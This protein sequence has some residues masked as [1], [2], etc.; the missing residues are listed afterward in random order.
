M[1][2]SPVSGLADQKRFTLS[3]GKST[4]EMAVDARKILGKNPKV[5]AARIFHSPP[6]AV[7]NRAYYVSLGS[8]KK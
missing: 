6:A 3:I 8:K 5:A 2:T 4:H 1:R 7:E